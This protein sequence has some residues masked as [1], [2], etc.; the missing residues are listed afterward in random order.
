MLHCVVTVSNR[1]TTTYQHHRISRVERTRMAGVMRRQRRMR[2]VFAQILETGA[3][4]ARLTSGGAPPLTHHSGRVGDHLYVDPDGS[5][6]LGPERNHP[7]GLHVAV[8]DARH[9]VDAIYRELAAR[10]LEVQVPDV[11]LAASSARNERGEHVVENSVSVWRTSLPR[12]GRF[13]NH[14]GVREPKRVEVDGYM[15]N[16]QS[17]YS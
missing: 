7:E 16:E 1:S 8:V 13:S 12:R 5:G 4:G 3:L 2:R 17:D 15:A 9:D 11:N 10:E 14:W 6:I